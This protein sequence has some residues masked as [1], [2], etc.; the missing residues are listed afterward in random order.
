MQ[1]DFNSRETL[2]GDC[3]QRMH[4]YVGLGIRRTHRDSDSVRLEAV[5][6]RQEKEADKKNA[7]KGDRCHFYIY[8]FQP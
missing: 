8:L 2:L 3:F 4:H 5:E 1:R 6:S 7:G